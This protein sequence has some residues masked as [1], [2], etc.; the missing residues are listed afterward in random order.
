MMESETLENTPDTLVEGLLT[1]DGNSSSLVTLPEPTI[2][3]YLWVSPA[4]EF[5]LN[6]LQSPDTAVFDYK[7]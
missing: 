5:K 2:T 4:T 7:Y 6:L 3:K 1:E